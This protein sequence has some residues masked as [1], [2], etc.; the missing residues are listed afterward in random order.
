MIPQCSKC[1]MD[2]TRE[3]LI[4]S[5]HNVE[6]CKQECMKSASCIGID[7]GNVN[8][9]CYLN[10]GTFKKWVNHNDFNSWKKNPAC[11]MIYMVIIANYISRFV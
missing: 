5:I 7:F 9:K 2:A 6:E 8:R 1:D 4:S 10:F 11:G 3:D